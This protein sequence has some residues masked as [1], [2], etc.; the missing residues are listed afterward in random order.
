MGKSKIKIQES[1]S[2]TGLPSEASVQARAKEMSAIGARGEESVVQRNREGE[3]REREG[4][5]KMAPR[6]CLTETRNGSW[7][8]ATAFASFPSRRL[9]EE[10][11]A[12]KVRIRSWNGSVVRETHFVTRARRWYR[13]LSMIHEHCD[14]S[15]RRPIPGSVTSASDYVGPRRLALSVLRS[16]SLSL[17]RVTVGIG[18]KKIL[19]ACVSSRCGLFS[20]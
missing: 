13:Y 10:W 17:A 19:A 4:N 20:N 7:S 8:E 3:K 1:G 14:E 2:S 16:S 9:G 15:K 18:E 6:V 11:P 5:S 12:R